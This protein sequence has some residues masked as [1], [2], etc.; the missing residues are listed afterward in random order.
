MRSGRR[1]SRSTQSGRWFSGGGS[2]N[3]VFSSSQNGGRTWTTGGLPGTTINSGGPWPRI[4]DP[5]V[6]FDPQDNV[7]LALGLGIDAGGSGHILLVNRS[8]DGGV[9]WSNPVTA[10]TAP[11]TFWDKTWITCDTWAESPHYGNCYIEFDDASAGDRMSMV[12]STDGGVTWGSVL[13]PPGCSSGLGGQ[14]VVQPNG[15]VIVPYSNDGGA[16]S[17]FRSTNGGTSWGDCVLV[18]NVTEHGVAANIRTFSLPSAEVAGDG[19]V[20]LAWQDC[21]F[22][23]NCQVNDIVYSS[24]LDGLTWSTVTRIPIDALDSHIDHFLPGIAVDKNTAGSSTH[25]AVAYYYFPNGDTCSTSTCQMTVGFTSSL[26]GGAS[27]TQGR[28]IGGPMHVPWIART[29]QGY[30]VGDYIS[31]SFTGDGKAHPVFS[32]AKAPDSGVNGSCYPNNTGCHQRLTSVS[33]DITQPPPVAPVRTRREPI[34]RGLH[35]HPEETP[36]APRTAN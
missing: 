19:K 17:S 6:A 16:E 35:R 24:S 14:P 5:S 21:R 12:T 4:S 36:L 32:L 15:N 28:L 22:R 30:M 31:T 13:S 7:W 10:G 18:S 2:S 29:D 26:D 9:T 25:L 33:V 1:S 11:G 20:Y 34:A 27:W 3:L 8:T 23:T